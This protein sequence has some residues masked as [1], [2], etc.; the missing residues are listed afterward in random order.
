VRLS[1]FCRVG[2]KAG[3]R[4]RYVMPL[5]AAAGRRVVA[6]DPRGMGDS[7]RPNSDHDMRTVV[8]EVQDFTEAVGL[9]PEGPIGVVGHDGPLNGDN[10]VDG[11]A[12][13]G[14]DSTIKS[15]L[16]PEGEM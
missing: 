12:Y 8:A 16:R 2:R 3:I 5:L 4:G 14:G 10:H 7:D 11:R 6:L 1:S 13:D 15:V 9:T